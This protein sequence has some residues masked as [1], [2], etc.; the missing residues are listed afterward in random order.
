MIGIPGT[1]VRP[2]I[3]ETFRETNA[4]G[5]IFFGP[6]FTSAR[7]FCSLIS[8]LEKTLGRRLIT[9]VDHEGGRVIHLREGITVFPDN[10]ALGQTQNEDYAVWQG[11]IEARELRRLGI[12]L[13]LAPTV[14]VLTKNFS[15][16]IGIR[17]YGLDPELV[18]KLGAA[19]IRM[20]Q[21]LG[22]SACAKHFPGQ[23]QSPSDAHLGLPVIPTTPEEMWK[24]HLKPFIAAIQAGVHAIMTSHPVYPK[25]DSRKQPATFSRRIVHGLLRRKLGFE[26]LILSDDLEMGALRGLCGTGESAVRAVEAGHDIVLVCHDRQAQFQVSKALLK[27]Y[28]SGRLN[29]KELEASAERIRIFRQNRFF[30]FGEG[31]PAAEPRGAELA[32][33]I[34]RE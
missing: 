28:R 7:Q 18:A 23:G 3:L 12:D 2:E 30:R 8:N 13:N 5:V 25:L 27:A 9:A 10:L 4:G 15:P 26:G 16:N 29:K 34:A 31:K 22:L 32:A 1:R 33:R 6:N 11:E 21:A 20:M 14:D 19:R 24:I 17:S